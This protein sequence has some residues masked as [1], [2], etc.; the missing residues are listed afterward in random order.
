M[1]D[2][3]AETTPPNSEQEQM[4]INLVSMEL[5]VFNSPHHNYLS[6]R[7]A[8]N[9]EILAI[10]GL[11]VNRETGTPVDVG[12]EKDT[13]RVM[14]MGP[15]TSIV[16]DSPINGD[17]V[18]FQGNPLETMQ[19]FL[20]IADA[21]HFINSQNLAYDPYELIGVGQN[22]NSVAHSLVVAM[23]EE[24]PEESER[25]WAPGHDRILLPTDWTSFYADNELSTGNT[26]KV[27]YG[28]AANELQIQNVIAKAIEDEAPDPKSDIYFDRDE[29]F[30]PYTPTGLNYA[31]IAEVEPQPAGHTP[32]PLSN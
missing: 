24:F 25:L 10:H 27:L 16:G 29:P 3:S 32:P 30:V 7:D 20:A 2:D 5:D 8:N 19:K 6:L 18:I 4:S 22:S 23:G 21:A 26:M 17:H 12:D 15:D 13:L 1:G 9:N 31:P 11:A 14:M 28:V